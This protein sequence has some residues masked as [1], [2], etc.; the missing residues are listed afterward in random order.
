MMQPQLYL[1]VPHQRS[2]R[3]KVL[4]A[5]HISTTST[6]HSSVLFVCE[7][8]ESVETMSSLLEVTTRKKCR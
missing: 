4:Y 8:N 5:L 2:R 3:T 7:V 6:V 1:A